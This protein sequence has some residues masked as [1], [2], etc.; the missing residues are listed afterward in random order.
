MAK[1]RCVR[2]LKELPGS[3][4]YMEGV[5][6]IGECCRETAS[7]PSAFDQIVARIDR[8][9][10]TAR[11]LKPAARPAPAPSKPSTTSDADR[12]AEALRYW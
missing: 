10:A 11:A 4:V 2:C 7:E 8:A 5:K 3:P 1:A 6:V 12:A 9:L